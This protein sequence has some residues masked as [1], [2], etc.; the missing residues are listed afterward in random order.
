MVDTDISNVDMCIYMS[1][2]VCTQL[3]V[4]FAVETENGRFDK[5]VTA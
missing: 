1:V 2:S 3:F 4:W 5:I